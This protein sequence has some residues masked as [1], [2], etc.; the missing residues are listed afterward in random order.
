MQAF[1]TENVNDFYQLPEPQRFCIEPLV[2][3]PIQFTNLLAKLD[4]H[5]QPISVLRQRHHFRG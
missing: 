1:N 2:I 4:A 5:Q 3:H